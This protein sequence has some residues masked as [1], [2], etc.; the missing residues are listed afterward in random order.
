M[1]FNNNVIDLKSRRKVT[2]EKTHQTEESSASVLDIVEKRQEIMQDERRIVRRTILTEFIGAFIIVPQKG[3]CSVSLYDISDDGMAFDIEGEHGQL[4]LEEEVAMRIYMNK[5]TYFPFVVKVS[6]A[7]Q[8]PEEGVIR[9][10]ASFVKGTINDVAL[11]HFV[12]FIESVS[13]CLEKDS[14]DVLVSNLR[15]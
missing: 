4:T 1:S 3:L 6:N 8:I 13:S 12:K 7:R 5:K 14:G 9:H 15:K 2:K 10:G 11:H